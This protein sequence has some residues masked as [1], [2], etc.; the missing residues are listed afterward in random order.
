[1]TKNELCVVGIMLLV[2][3]LLGLSYVFCPDFWNGLGH[4]LV[5]WIG[6]IPLEPTSNW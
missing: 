6:S 3:G 1:M 4:E 2:L 5:T